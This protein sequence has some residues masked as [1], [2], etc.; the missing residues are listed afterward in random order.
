MQDDT[1]ALNV[2]TSRHYLQEYQL[3]M[4]NDFSSCLFVKISQ[5]SAYCHLIRQLLWPLTVFVSSQ[6]DLDTRQT[7]LP[8]KS[9]TDGHFCLVRLRHI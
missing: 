6:Q 3:C 9:P 1:G 2:S 8:S 4:S 5:F 7:H